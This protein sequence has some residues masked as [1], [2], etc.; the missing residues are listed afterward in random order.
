[1]L[2]PKSKGNDSSALSNAR[3]KGNPPNRKHTKS[4]KEIHLDLLDQILD[5]KFL[6]S[7]SDSS[8]VTVLKKVILLGRADV[9]QIAEDLPLDK[10]VVSRHLT[11]LSEAGILNRTKIGKQV[12]YEPDPQNILKRFQAII[13]GVQQV[14]ANCCPIVFPFQK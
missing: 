9:S 12:F 1:M 8:R 10:S 11:F 3:R 13:D 4:S 5:S 6:N 2:S 14:I 7:L